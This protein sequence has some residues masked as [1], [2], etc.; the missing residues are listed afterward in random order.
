MSRSN[1]TLD[2]WLGSSSSGQKRP[3]GGKNGAGKSGRSNAMQKSSSSDGGSK[4]REQLAA[5]ARET[6]MHLES[7]IPDLPMPFKP[8]ESERV[9]LT[10]LKPLTSSECP[11]RNPAKIKILVINEDTLN[12]AVSMGAYAAADGGRVAVLNMASHANPGGGWLKGALAQEEAL[13]YRSS[14][15]LALHRRFY[16]WKQQMGLYSPDVVIIRSDMA[17]GHKLYDQDPKNYSYVSVLSIAALRCP[18]LTTIQENTPGGVKTRKVFAK[19]ADRT[20]TKDKMR[21]C[22]RMAARKGHRSLVLGALGCGAFRNPPEEVANCWLE[23]LREDE[24]GGGWWDGIW[25][26]IFDTR[27]EGNF[28]VFQK[29]LG[30]QEI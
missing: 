6:Q 3:G 28:E 23:V 21:L 4:R 8:E 26:A 20:M 30:D 24:F 29:V 5:T 10:S 14:L 22:L 7:I 11:R 15:S 9:F 19:G 27:N 2:G 17:S 18:D 12:A 16:P 1:G 13:C 25:F